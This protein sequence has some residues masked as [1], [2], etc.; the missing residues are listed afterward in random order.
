MGHSVASS[1]PAGNSKWV[2]LIGRALILVL[3]AGSIEIT[4]YAIVTYVKS[5]GVFF[6][7]ADV[8]QDY[9]EYLRVRDSKLGWVARGRD[10]DGARP[11]KRYSGTKA[12]VD[13]FGDSFTQGDE[14]A[15]EQTWASALASKIGCRVRNYGVGG[16]GSDQAYMRYLAIDEPSKVVVLSHLSENII[17]NVNRFRNFIYPGPEFQFK[18]R[19]VIDGAVIRLAGLPN[20]ATS[21]IADFLYDPGKYLSD[22]YFIPGGSSGNQFASFPYSWRI[23]KAVT[24]QD[25]RSLLLGAP[26]FAGFYSERHDS[27]ALELTARILENFLEHSRS[28]GLTGIVTIIPTCRDF[29]QQVAHGAFPYAPL[30]ERLTKASSSFVD[31]GS[32]I[33]ARNVAFRDIYLSCSGHMN[34]KGHAIMANILRYHRDL[35]PTSQRLH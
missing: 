14:V 21:E 11:D 32:E 34:E 3:F 10:A 2:R 25:F 12:C 6:S 8:R 13:V 1:L 19:F 31:F 35:V 30:A 26:R 27:G 17:R 23:A 5:K 4:S 15:D 28:R 33:L 22:D 7:A 29:E 9:N 24:N 16:Y 18:P 20:L